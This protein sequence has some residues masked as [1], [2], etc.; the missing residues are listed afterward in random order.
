MAREIWV[1]EVGSNNPEI[2]P[3][4]TSDWNTAKSVAINYAR[5]RYTNYEVIPY[6]DILP[7]YYIIPSKLSDH[8]FIEVH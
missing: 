3:L 6:P 4:A 2:I 8:T 1:Q 5:E 7:G